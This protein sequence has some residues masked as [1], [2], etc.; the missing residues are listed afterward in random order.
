MNTIIVLVSSAASFGEPDV[1][2]GLGLSLFVIVLMI[3]AWLLSLFIAYLIVRSG[4]KA[5]VQALVDQG[6]VER[7]L[8]QAQTMLLN[9]L[10][11]RNAPAPAPNTLADDTS[12]WD[13]LQ[14]H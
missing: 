4:V 3:A 12:A 1:K 9:Q 7:E 8:M 6:R 14:K 11:K 10:V 13:E 2:P 5:G